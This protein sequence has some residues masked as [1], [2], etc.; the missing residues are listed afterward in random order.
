MK[1]FRRNTLYNMVSLSD[2]A[3]LEQISMAVWVLQSPTE[4]Q[5]RS[6]DLSYDF[7]DRVSALW[8]Q[9]LPCVNP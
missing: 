3:H 5:R 7:K 8:T 4:K 2:V 9:D 6:P 1:Y